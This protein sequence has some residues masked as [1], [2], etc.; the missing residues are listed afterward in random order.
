MITT[1]PMVAILTK[2]VF[3]RT[4][5]ECSFKLNYHHKRTEVI[6]KRKIQKSSKENQVEPQAKRSK[7]RRQETQMQRQTSEEAQKQDSTVSYLR[8]TMAI[9]DPS[10]RSSPSNSED[11]SQQS[12]K[13]EGEHSEEPKG[14]S[15][16]PSPWRRS[17][18]YFLSSREEEFDEYFEDMFL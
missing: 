6:A 14:L 3:S 10:S 9:A 8:T 17:P 5:P 4:L 18:D 13:G 2:V 12:D 15:A 11:D 1:I 16:Q 7:K